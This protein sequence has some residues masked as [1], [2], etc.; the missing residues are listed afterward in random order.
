MT[1]PVAG[2]PDSVPGMNVDSVA[3]AKSGTQWAIEAAGQQAVL[4]E[5]GGGLRT[6]TV[7]GREV[8][9]G[10]AADEITPAGHGHILAPWPN[11]IRDGQYTFEGT[12]HQ[13]PLTEP[14]KH[15]AIHGLVNWSRWNVVDQQP[16][17]VTLEYDMPA[18]VGYPW[19]LLFRSR[20]SIGAGGL[21]ADHDVT[22]TSDHDVP[23]GF[24]VHPYLR[25]PGVAVDDV[26]LQVPGR[27]RVLADGRL[28]PIGAVKVA[29]TDYDYAE[30]RRIGDAVLDTTF[31]DIAYDA[32]GISTVTLTAPSGE[33]IAVWCDEAFRWWQV[34]TSD[35]LKA[36]RHRRAVAVE[37]MTCPPDAFRSARDL[38]VL[39]PGQTWHAS[40]GIRPTPA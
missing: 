20:W 31:G 40:W 16:D 24:S 23:F 12:S 34:F 7:N 14:D 1:R 21:R 33:S 15:N 9:D 6:Y 2:E 10:Y 26:T 30:P 25:F 3:P 28:L 22:N 27:T 29:G 35:T 4:V 19:S 13:L 5:V 18:Q 38:V 36:E 39:V 37:P 17:A 32:D 11:R 8:V